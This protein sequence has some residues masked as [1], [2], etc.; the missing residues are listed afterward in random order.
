MYTLRLWEHF[1]RQME[2][3]WCR[4]C[5]WVKKGF[6]WDRQID[7]LLCGKLYHTWTLCYGSDEDVQ[8]SIN[9]RFVYSYNTLSRCNFCHDARQWGVRHQRW[10]W[11]PVIMYMVNTLWYSLCLYTEHSWNKIWHHLMH[12]LCIIILPL[13]ESVQIIIICLLCTVSIKSWYFLISFY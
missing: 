3:K 13:Q 5:L 11:L 7:L 6:H 9:D 8:Y 1:V 12:V 2:I 10:W 4:K